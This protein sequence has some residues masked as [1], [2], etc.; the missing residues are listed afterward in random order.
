LLF[1]IFYDAYGV[2]S[3]LK[4]EVVTVYARKDNWEDINKGR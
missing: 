3:K 2:E 1:Y 4:R